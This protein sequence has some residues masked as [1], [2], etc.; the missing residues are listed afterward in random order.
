MPAIG[1]LDPDGIDQ[2]YAWPDKPW[3]RVNMVTS[4]DGAAAAADGLSKGIATPADAHLFGALR[5]RADAIL[6]GGSTLRA[7]RYRP[8]PAKPRYEAARAAAGQRPAP[9]IAIVSRSLDLPLTDDLFVRPVERPIVLTS[10]DAPAGAVTAVSAVADVITCGETTVAPTA[11]L[12]AL[13]DR[14]LT[15]VHCEGGPHLLNQLAQQD[16]IDEWCITISPRVVGAT[17]ADGAEP[18]RMLAGG[19]LP[20]SPASLQ[21]GHVLEEDGTLFLR[22]GRT[23]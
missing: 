2:A 19:P 18:R 17:F 3:L 15:W 8:A 11:A 21:L 13:R 14:G 9:V 23:T 6:I 12:A 16:L 20:K 4:L 22:Y 1:A 7:E 10:V 5:G